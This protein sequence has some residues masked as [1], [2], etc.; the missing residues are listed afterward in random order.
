MIAFFRGR[1]TPAPVTPHARIRAITDKQAPAAYVSVG[2]PSKR[3]PR[4]PV[5][6]QA[7]IRL[8]HGEQFPVVIRDLSAGGCR[9]EYSRHILPAGRVRLTEPS[10]PIS[11]WA[12]IAWRADGACG[13]R[14][15]RRPAPTTPG[16]TS[17]T[18]RER[19]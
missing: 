18:A 4:R 3:P 9:L 10:L 13:L 1:R 15:D 7:L 17:Q 8:Q 19:G 6:K 16:Q 11:L 5:F 2:R 14:F 12:D